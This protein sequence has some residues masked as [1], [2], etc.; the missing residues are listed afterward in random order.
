MGCFLVFGG[1]VDRCVGWGVRRGLHEMRGSVSVG[2]VKR[3]EITVRLGKYLV[4]SLS[5]SQLQGKRPK[6]AS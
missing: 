4:Q 1:G 2:L 6:N 3:I 5:H